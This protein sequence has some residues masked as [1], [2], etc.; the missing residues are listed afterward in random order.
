MYTDRNFKSKKA[1]KDA[2]AAGEVV[3]VFQ[4]NDMVGRTQAVRDTPSTTVSVEGPH[5]P[6]PHRWYASVV[7]E[8]GRIVRV[9]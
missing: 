1:L 9:K 4:P 5:S 6:E 3:N 8:Y 2:V 7:V